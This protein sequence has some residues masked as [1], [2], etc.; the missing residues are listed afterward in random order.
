[1][2]DLRAL[3]LAVPLMLSGSLLGHELGYRFA[4]P[5]GAARAHA[6]AADGH[7]YFAY[8]P[9]AVSIACALCLYG[10][11]LLALRARGG[12]SSSM[13]PGLIALLPPVAFVTQ[14]HLERLVHEGGI[15]WSAALDPAFALGLLL[16]APFALAAL[17]FARALARLGEWIGH[18]LGA[19]P[20]P[21]VAR[22]PPTLRERSGFIG[23]PLA[24]LASG[25]SE[26]GP[27]S[28]I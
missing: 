8:L 15:P 10:F 14:E 16:Q 17:A 12:R 1:M 4:M 25:S 20:R 19:K 11:V 3:L 7:A 18:T 22:L 13:P 9:L 2:R 23:V 6:L 28:R 26:R 27:P 24:A 21:S 5:D